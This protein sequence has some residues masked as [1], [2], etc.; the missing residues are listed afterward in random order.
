V[1]LRACDIYANCASAR[2]KVEIPFIALVPAASTPM[3]TLLPT[4]QSIWYQTPTP[5]PSQT[6]TV[7]P[8]LV[9]PVLPVIGGEDGD[10]QPTQSPDQPLLPLAAAALGASVLQAAASRRVEKEALAKSGTC[11]TVIPE[12]YVGRHGE[13][14]P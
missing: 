2:G 14:Q 13:N 3:P 4:Q 6:P 9:F 11:R 7:Q 5:V 12:V 1:V 8:T 10:N